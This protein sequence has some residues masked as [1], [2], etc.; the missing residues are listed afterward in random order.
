MWRGVKNHKLKTT[1]LGSA[2]PGKSRQIPSLSSGLG[3]EKPRESFSWLCFPSSQSAFPCLQLVCRCCPTDGSHQP[4]R[5]HLPGDIREDAAA[6]ALSQPG[7]SCQ[8]TRGGV[9]SLPPAPLT[10]AVPQPE[11]RSP[12]YRKVN[13]PIIR[14][15]KHEIF[16]AWKVGEVT[17]KS[18][19]KKVMFGG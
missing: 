19:A 9:C 7:R 3:F 13:P 17:V 16:P 11:S 10:A 2:V 4:G 8:G 15:P 6:A 14:F 12:C 18:C 1:T 5:L